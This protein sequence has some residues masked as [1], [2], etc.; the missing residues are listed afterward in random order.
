MSDTESDAQK[1]KS[2]SDADIEK[3]A[4]LSRLTLEQDERKELRTKINSVIKYFQ[5]LEELDTT[6]VEPLSHVHGQQNTFRADTCRETGALGEAI[7][8]GV[9]DRSGNFIKVPLV[10]DQ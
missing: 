6:E 8:Q 4:T 2:L 3:L 10:I 1:G 7:R 9:P 5:K